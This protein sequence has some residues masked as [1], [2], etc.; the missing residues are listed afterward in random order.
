MAFK[1]GLIKYFVILRIQKNISYFFVQNE[2]SAQLLKSIG[3]NN[4]KTVGDTR[5]DRVH[6]ICQNRKEFPIVKAFTQNQ[7]TLIIGSAW[8][9]DI[10]IIAPFLNSFDQT[11]KIVIASHEI[12]EDTIGK[13]KK[14]KTVAFGATGYLDWTAGAT[15]EQRDRYRNWKNY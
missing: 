6:E 5:F 12:D 15:K 8:Q 13:M 10:D 1:V 11:L 9:E 7:C 14:K 3:L 2:S 4:Q